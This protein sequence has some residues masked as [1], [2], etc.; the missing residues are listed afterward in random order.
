LALVLPFTNEEQQVAV[1]GLNVED[2]NLDLDAGLPGD[3]EELALAVTLHVQGDNACAAV[4]AR[5]TVSDLQPSAHASKLG[6]EEVRIH[7]RRDTTMMERFML[8]LKYSDWTWLRF[9]PIRQS[10]NGT[11]T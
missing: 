5:Q 7:E 9:P 4:P 2:R 11:S 6:V 1:A 8:S 10:D 3:L